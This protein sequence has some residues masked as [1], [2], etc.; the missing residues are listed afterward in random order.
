MKNSGKSFT[1]KLNVKEGTVLRESTAANFAVPFDPQDVVFAGAADE[2]PVLATVEKAT[3]A[4]DTSAPL[5]TEYKDKATDANNA[6]LKKLQGIAQTKKLAVGKK[7]TA[8]QYVLVNDSTVATVNK[9]LTT[10]AFLCNK[11]VVDQ[12]A[13][14]L[15]SI[16]A[17]VA[18]G[19]Y[20]LA[21]AQVDYEVSK[22]YA[23]EVKNDDGTTK[24]A[25]VVAEFKAPVIKKVA[26]IASK[27]PM[28]AATKVALTGTTAAEISSIAGTDEAA[29][30]YRLVA[31]STEKGAKWASAVT[32]VSSTN[33]LTID[34]NTTSKKVKITHTNADMAGITV[35]LAHKSGDTWESLGKFYIT[36]AASA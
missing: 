20:Y 2:T 29:S 16:N 25:E 3:K 26:S 10:K 12:T 17:N 13:G 21:L 30:N 8:W 33:N 9:N 27:T 19:T 31:T 24:T 11:A 35:I 14:K 23:A 7:I 28:I 15:T 34:V 5:I 32:D 6:D 1:I 36:A 18:G 22:A 4:N